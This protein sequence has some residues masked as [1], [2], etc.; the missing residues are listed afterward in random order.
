VSAVPGEQARR[1]DS[2]LVTR[3]LDGDQ[4]AWTQLVQRYSAYVFTILSNGFNL[5]TPTAQD[6]FQEVFTRAFRRLDTLKDPSALKPWI[7]QL[8]RRAAIDRIRATRPEVDIDAV[9]ER[10]ESDPQLERIEQAMAIHRALDELPDLYR[11]VVAR[12]FIQDHSYAAIAE[13]LGLPHGTIAS[14]ISRGLAMLRTAL[15]EP[16]LQRA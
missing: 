3:C 16:A 4:D 14:R 7:A 12:F 8:T 13:D 11:E 1:R 2:E 5:D 9:V 6:V 10:G 15:S